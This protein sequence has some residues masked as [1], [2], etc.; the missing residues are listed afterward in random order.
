MVKSSIY[1]DIEEFLDLYYPKNPK[2]SPY[3]GK[4]IVANKK[5]AEWLVVYLYGKNHI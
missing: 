3:K 1:Q 2:D 4:A 5:I